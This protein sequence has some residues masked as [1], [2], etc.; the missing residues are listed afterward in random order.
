MHNILEWRIARLERLLL[1]GKDDEERLKQ[2][3]GGDLFSAYMS[4]RNRIPS[5]SD[6]NKAYP[7]F[8]LE[9]LEDKDTKNLFIKKYNNIRKH[10]LINN[11][12]E[13]IHLPSMININDS[14]YD[15]FNDYNIMRDY[16]I[17]EY[18]KFR[19]FEVLK[20]TSLDEIEDFV[21]KFTTVRNTKL[22]NKA[23][24]SKKIYEDQDWIVYKVMT[25]YAAAE[26]GK[27]TKWCIAGNYNGHTD[28]GLY[29]FNSYIRKHNLSDEYFN[30]PDEELDKPYPHTFNKGGGYYFFINKS[31]N[32]KYCILQN[33]DR[34]IESIWDASD[35]LKGSSYA[36]WMASDDFVELPKIKEIPELS[37]LNYNEAL[38]NAIEDGRIDLVESLLNNGADPD[39]V[40][41]SGDTAVTMSILQSDYDLL[42]LLLKAGADPNKRDNDGTSPLVWTMIVN[43]PD[44]AKI[45]I[46]NGANINEVAR[47]G[48]RIISG[49]RKY[50]DEIY[51][52]LLNAGAVEESFKYK[53]IN[54]FK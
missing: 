30:V 7:E 49:A 41:K 17:S 34:E 16:I 4:I 32:D 23:E 44:L 18:N 5:I 43:E 52:L 28:K 45:L 1:E 35:R 10:K 13:F 51:N 42:N 29:F 33:R 47:D 48:T 37:N 50:S 24:G 53:N 40:N 38:F 54:R 3:L 36:Y 12:A 8:T 27:G 14:L 9:E 22:S 20:K 2:H 31:T 15:Y 11:N 19:S 26:L 6:L 25:Y 39:A 46:D 21:G